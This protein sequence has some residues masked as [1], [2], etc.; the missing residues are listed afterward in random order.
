M[1]TSS[2]KKSA[3]NN[4]V[5]QSEWTFWPTA[6]SAMAGIGIGLLIGTYLGWI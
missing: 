6:F 4:S 2:N 3:S 1:I 5:F